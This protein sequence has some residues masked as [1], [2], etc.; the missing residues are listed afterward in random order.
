MLRCDEKK[1]GGATLSS[2]RK[3]PVPISEYLL[4]RHEEKGII[5]ERPTTQAIITISKVTSEAIKRASKVIKILLLNLSYRS[6][7]VSE[8]CCLVIGD[9]KYQKMTK[10]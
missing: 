2:S 10:V 6:I 1:F 3:F 7:P 5:V 8:V 4:K 9:Q